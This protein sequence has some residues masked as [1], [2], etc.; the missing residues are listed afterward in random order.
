M[1]R[2]AEMNINYLKDFVIL[3]RYNNYLEASEELFISQSTLSKHRCQDDQN[4]QIVN[5]SSF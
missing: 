5:W 1:E 4:I 2:G 3:S